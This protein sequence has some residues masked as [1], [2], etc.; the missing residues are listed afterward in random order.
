MKSIQRI[1]ALA[2]TSVFIVSPVFAQKPSSAPTPLQK[3][4]YVLPYPGIL[5]D[6]PLFVLKE[7]RDKILDFLI[8]DPLRKAEFY[9]LQADKRL[10]MGV[11]LIDKGKSELAVQTIAQGE[12]YFTQVVTV[13]EGV[14]QSE[15]EMP[16]YILERVIASMGKHEEVL[17]ETLVKN[18]SVQSS[19]DLLKK[20]M[21]DIAKFR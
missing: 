1:I 18:S 4:E 3:V 15:K 21:E 11:M 16:S 20:T 13:F 7:F 10:G 17:T 12:K 19:L 6:H 8:V 9:V 5:P 14:K 2:V